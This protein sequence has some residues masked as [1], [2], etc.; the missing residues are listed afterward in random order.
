MKAEATKK[1]PFWE[2]VGRSF[3]YV[4]K[5]GKLLKAGAM[6][7]LC[8]I[9]FEIAMGLP[10]LCAIDSNQCQKGAKNIIN[11]IAIAL[12]SIGI[13]INYCRVIILKAPV[14][15][16]SLS[17]WKRMLKY[18]LT[19]IMLSVFIS[20]PTIVSIVIMVML[21]I[22]D[23][24]LY[25]MSFSMTLLFGVLFAPIYLM[26]PA[27]SV[28][29]K[30]AINFKKVYQLAKGNKMPIF[31][32]QFILM[33]PYWLLATMYGVFYGMMDTNSYI[34]KLISS[35]IILLLGLIDAALK[36]AFF[37]HIYQFFTYYSKKKNQ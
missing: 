21:G 30:E 33:T 10:L 32:G 19:S 2:T 26:F 27:I 25:M 34:I 35:A 14:D 23:H 22:S 15:F 18:S 9:I 6:L 12:V 13:I 36:G 3:K 29:N 16:I 11:I 17:F 4:L 20:I 8:I 31:F 37:A 1:L 28:D 24:T 5:N 7:A